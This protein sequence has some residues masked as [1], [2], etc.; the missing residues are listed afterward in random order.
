MTLKEHIISQTEGSLAHFFETARKVPTDKLEWKPLDAGRSV[1]DQA[2]EVAYCP[3]WVPGI[4][5]ARGFDPEGWSSYEETRKAWTTLDACEAAAKENMEKFKES[6]L[7][8]PDAELEDSPELPWGKFTYRAV[9]TFVEWNCNYHI[10][11]INYIQ[12][13]YGDFSM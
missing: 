13:L 10:G 7:S 12:T 4:V 8:F 9:L 11:Q 5:N 3:L 6:V 1:L 2:Q